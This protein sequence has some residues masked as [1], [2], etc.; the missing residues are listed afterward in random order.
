MAKSIAQLC[1]N[2]I[3]DAMPQQTVDLFRPIKVSKY[4][5]KLATGTCALT[6]DTIQKTYDIAAV[7]LSGQTAMLGHVNELLL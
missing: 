3:P 5:R 6:Y 4:H 2:L 7:W 1:K